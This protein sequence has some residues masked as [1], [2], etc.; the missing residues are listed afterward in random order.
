MSFLLNATVANCTQREFATAYYAYDN[1]F[2][3]YGITVSPLLLTT[4]IVGLAAASILFS[5]NGCCY[6]CF[7]PKKPLPQTSEATPLIGQNRPQQSSSVWNVFSRTSK[8][9]LATGL[10]VTTTV[11]TIRSF[12]WLKLH[13]LQNPVFIAQQ[14]LEAAYN[15]CTGGAV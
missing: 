12:G 2:P 5:L 8:G 7:K 6:G 9:L 1:T 10:F 3:Y 4:N 15:N 14:I 13:D 11:L